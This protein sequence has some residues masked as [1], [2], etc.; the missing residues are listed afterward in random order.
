MEFRHLQQE[1]EDQSY[2]FSGS[3][4][5]TSGVQQIIDQLTALS[6][7]CYL[8]NVAKEKNGLDYL[9][10]FEVNGTVIWVIDQLDKEMIESGRWKPED[11]HCTILLPSEY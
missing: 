2:F 5:L 3:V 4:Y 11:N 6:I 9:Q 8:R 7:I 10:R 1:R